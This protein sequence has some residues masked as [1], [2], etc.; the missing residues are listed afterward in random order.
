MSIDNKMLFDAI[1][2]SLFGGS[3]QYGRLPCDIRTELRAQGV[4]SLTALAY[5]DDPAFKYKQVADFTRM[6]R[7]QYE[8]VSLLEEASIQVVIIKGTASGIYYPKAYLRT[9]GDIDLLVKE[10]NYQLSIQILKGDGWLQTGE[11]GESHTAFY[12][13]CFLLELHQS[14][15]ALNMVSEGKF[16]LEYLYEGFNDIQIGAIDEP[17]C[18]FPMLPWKQNGLELI[19]HFWEHLYN[20][21][22]LRHVIDWMMFVRVKLHT[23]EAYEEFYPV[24]EQAGLLGLAKSLTRM[25]QLFLGLTEDITWCQ[26]VEDSVCE[27]LMSFI[28]EQGNFGHKKND[29]KAAKVMSSYRTPKAFLRGM[30]QKGLNEWGAVKKHRWLRP[31]AWIY[32]VQKG[33][34]RYLKRGGLQQYQIDRKENRRR[35]EM[36]DQINGE[37]V[38]SQ[39]ISMPHVSPAEIIRLKQSS[40]Q[41]IRLLYKWLT[42]APFRVPLYHLE[43]LYFLLR[44]P[45]FGKPKIPDMDRQAVEQNVTFIYKS[46]NRQRLAKRCYRV[47]KEYYPKARVIIADDSEKPLQIHD[48]ADEDLILHLPF[49]SGLSQGLIAAL[50]EVKTPYTMRLDDDELLTPSSNIHEQLRFLE[51]HNE[52]DLVGLQ[53]KYHN[54]EHSAAEYSRIRMNRNLII[55]AGTMI[56]G[57]EVVYKTADLFLARTD[58]YRKIGYDPNIRMIIHHEFFYRA[59]G[60]IICVQDPHSFVMHCHNHF[61]RKAYRKPRGDF[62][63]DS[64]YI[65]KKHGSSFR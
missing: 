4:E 7:A 10:E 27:D 50:A 40:K 38:N 34:E 30:Q 37:K 15:P 32:S 45:L 17:K 60:K 36:F 59:A 22:G 3:N 8:A 57:R 2:I 44:Y 25:C 26:D 46:F 63:D 31:F 48:L 51:T 47:I 14:P 58:S 5:P 52:V 42:R 21:I 33:S 39:Q 49:N 65:S 9:Y 20:G 61:E 16:I 13:N 55:P 1:Q 35:Q 43:N 53:A 54:P 18:Q 24:L 29:D 12:K 19:W 23:N 41:H 62:L 28:I 64:V 11:V 56:D 6:I